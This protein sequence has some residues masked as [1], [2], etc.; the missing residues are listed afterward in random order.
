ME[1][2]F[3]QSS[4]PKNEAVI[5]Y[6]IELT[7]PIGKYYFVLKGDGWSLDKSIVVSDINYPSFIRDNNNLLLLLQSREN[8]R[9]FVYTIGS[10]GMAEI[11]G[12]KY[13][14]VDENGL[15]VIH[16]DDLNNFYAVIGDNTGEVQISG[17]DSRSLKG[18][19]PI[20]K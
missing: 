2:P 14:Q 16:I 1:Y 11:I 10:Y 9:V 20:T 13:Y 19:A 15:L 6:E 18:V 17:R 5:T 8:F 7:D 3:F 12:W 4:E